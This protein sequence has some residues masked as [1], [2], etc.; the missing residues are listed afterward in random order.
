MSVKQYRK[1][2]VVIEAIEY[3]GE[4]YEEIE[5]WCG[6]NIFR[7]D[8][9]A[10]IDTLEGA[11]IVRPGWFIIRGVKNEHY[12]CEPSVFALTYEEVK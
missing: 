9:V 4:N 7:L 6:E 5:A 12:P 2:P 11:M 10:F 8:D 1:K 3:T